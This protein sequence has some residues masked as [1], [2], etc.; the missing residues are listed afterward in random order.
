ML[1]AFMFV[2]DPLIN[3]YSRY[4]EHQ[5]DIYGLEVTHGVF[6]SNGQVATAAFQKLGEKSYSYPNPSPV[7]VFWTYTH[8][9]IADRMEFSLTYDPWRTP[10]GPK[11]IK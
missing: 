6:P 4:L 3:G 7:Y 2:A 8:P 1:T 9:P 10:E 5:A 11:Y